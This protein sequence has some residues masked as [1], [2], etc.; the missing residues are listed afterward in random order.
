MHKEIGLSTHGLVM[1]CCKWAAVRGR[2]GRR[3][4]ER[5]C[6]SAMELFF[7]IGCRGIGSMNGFYFQVQWANW[8]RLLDGTWMKR[9]TIGNSKSYEIKQPR[10]P[11]QQPVCDSAT[12]GVWDTAYR[13]G[14][15]CHFLFLFV[16][17]SLL[18]KYI[19]FYFVS[20]LVLCIHS[21]VLN[22]STFWMTSFD[23]F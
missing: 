21:A 18:R 22:N 20:V 3:W 23:I 19:R 6:S 10:W 1:L 13:P 12:M 15:V 8:W 5:L 17:I 11:N 2:S 4:W 9:N 7:F 16:P 14:N